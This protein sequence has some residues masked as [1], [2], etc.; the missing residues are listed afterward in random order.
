MRLVGS[1]PSLARIARLGVLDRLDRQLDAL[2][3]STE[4]FKAAGPGHPLPEELVGQKNRQRLQSLIEM[5]RGLP[6]LLLH[7]LL[8]VVSVV[9]TN[10]SGAPV[11]L[12]EGTDF[13]VNTET[14]TLLRLNS[15]GLGSLWEAEPVTVIY[16]A[17]YGAK[18]SEAHTVPATP[19]Q[20]TVSQSVAFSCDYSV[21]YANGTKLTRVSASPSTGQYSVAAGVYTFAAADAGQSLTIIYGAKSAPVDITEVCLRL[22]TARF[23]AK[24][25]DPALVQQETP[26][27]G[28]QRWWIG[29]TPGQHSPFTPD[30][31]FMLEPYVMPV[32][33]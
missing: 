26:G 33:A 1:P 20:I 16:M 3:K 25:R 21:A 7:L 15:I 22:V 32:V 6:S 4:G 18:V 13:R 12:T 8:G 27:V 2:R 19:Y 28:T 9:Q 23:R 24:D 17:G 30:I 5:S 14:G 29:S 10:S 31:E 11:T